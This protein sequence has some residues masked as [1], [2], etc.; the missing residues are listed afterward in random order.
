MCQNVYIN[1][2]TIMKILVVANQKGGVGKTTL[3]A[4][5]AYAALEAGKR[6][7]LVDM[8]RQGS[9]SLSFPPTGQGGGLL[10]SELFAEA[11]SNKLPEIISD[12]LSMVRSDAAL[13]ALD[14]AD[15]AS[16]RR[17]GRALRAID[18]FDVCIVDTPPTLGMGLIA[19][20]AAAD[21]V[22]TPVNIG[23]YELAAVGELVQ[24]I[25]KVKAQGMNPK[26]KHVGILI[27]KTNTRSSEEVE[28][29]QGLRKKYGS[30]I[31]STELAERAAVRKAVARRK[32][33]WQSPNGDG[34]RKA[35][36]EWRSACNYILSK[37]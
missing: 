4:H 27:M 12:Q 5:L 7:L 22:V 20:L 19:A 6:V 30:A 26:L 24:T 21:S 11:V 32:P 16:A 25:Q 13:M 23:L 15:V 1:Y 37:I 35:A 18:G 28:A 17:P 29:L 10:A 14:R 2:L 34:H 33:V 8:D 31:I 36:S 9:L 3:T